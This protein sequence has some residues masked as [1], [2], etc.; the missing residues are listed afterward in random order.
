[1]IPIC[2]ELNKYRCFNYY[3]STYDKVH[4]SVSVRQ[5]E[6]SQHGGKGNLVVKRLAVE[7]QEWRV[8]L[9]VVTTPEEQ[10][11]GVTSARL[12]YT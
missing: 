10:D 8:D 7:L 1:M 6:Q 4:L 11:M 2:C 3:V 5:E 12:V 9:D